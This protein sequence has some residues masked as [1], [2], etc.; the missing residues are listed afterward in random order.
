[1]RSP[2]RVATVLQQ[3]HDDEAW[4][5]V[6]RDALE[7]C[8]RALPPA[9]PQ[10]LIAVSHV[11]GAL[12]TLGRY[13]EAR[14]IL[15]DGLALAE[16]DPIAAREALGGML[17]W[18]GAC[19]QFSGTKED[20]VIAR[21]RCLEFVLARYGPESHHALAARN[22]LAVVL[23]NNRQLSEAIEVARGIPAAVEKMYPPGHP[24]R[25]DAY[26]MMGILL[27]ADNQFEESERY[28]M[29]AYQINSDA[30]KEFD[31]MTEQRIRGLRNLYS[32]WPGHAEQLYRWCLDGIKAR[33]MLARSHEYQNLPDALEFAR[34]ECTDAGRP[35]SPTTLLDAVWESRDTLAPPGHARRAAFYANFV[36]AAV[37]HARTQHAAE[38]MALADESLSYATEPENAKALVAAARDMLK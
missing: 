4:L 22:N 37:G 33:L 20:A 34:K 26:A 9:H 14:P 13:D 10:R 31:W 24:V 7:R 21:R 15:R 29:L 3:L 16:T 19:E 38:A 11:G 27:G 25:A 35:E 23:K 32:R 12:V 6:A 18:L 2:S 36:R 8:D 28:L 5:R 17:N 1:M 30:V